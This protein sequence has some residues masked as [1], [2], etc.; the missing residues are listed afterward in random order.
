MQSC[1]VVGL[2]Y[3]GLPTALIVAKSGLRVYGVDVNE[4]IV[5]KI[6]SNEVHIKENKLPELLNQVIKNKLFTAHTNVIKADVFVIAVPTPFEVNKKEIPFA[7]LEYVYK[8]AESISK[9]IKSGDLLILESTC[10][11]NTTKE[12]VEII[13]KNISFNIDEIHFAYCPERVLPGFIL[14]EL[15]NNDRVIGGFTEN[16][17]IKAKD[18]YSR[19]CKGKMLLTD[20]KTAELVKLSENAYRDVNI[21][22]ANELSIV[23]SNLNIN[24]RNLINIAN[25]HPRVNILN[26]GCGVGGHCIAVDPWF[27]ISNDPENTN[28]IKTARKV[29]NYKSDWI[30]KNILKINNELSLR[31]NRKPILG[32]L[33]LTFKPNV[34]DIRESPALKIYQECK[35]NN[36]SVLPCEPNLKNSQDI[37]LFSLDEIFNKCDV[38]FVLVAHKEFKKIS[39]KENIVDYCGI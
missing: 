6:N 11:V 26:P 38:I 15:V 20:S 4:E 13:K 9:V 25:H 17:S 29:N 31:L 16:A 1:C 19:F 33:G 34:D 3:I 14:E 8:A 7:N 35:K 18:F 39:S 24:V 32:L 2:G 28:L 5:D 30:V 10:P 12:V 37:D 36:I 21:A 22:F 23:A 27:I